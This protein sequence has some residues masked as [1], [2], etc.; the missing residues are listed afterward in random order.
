M[1]KIIGIT[2]RHLCEGDY[3]A[4]IEKRVSAWIESDNKYLGTFLCQGKM[5]QLVRQ[6][7]EHMKTTENASQIN[8]WLQNFDA[9]LP[10][11]DSLDMEHAKV[12]VE[13]TLKKC[14]MQ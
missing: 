9:A 8:K 11:P 2:N 13:K 4:Q 7:Y 14:N 5:P 1:C 10:H 3:Y 12:F 6:K